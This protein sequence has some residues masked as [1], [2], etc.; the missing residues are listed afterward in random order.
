MTYVLIHLCPLSPDFDQ[1]RAF[2]ASK[3]EVRADRAEPN[4]HAHSDPT[5][6]CEEITGSL[7]HGDDS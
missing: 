5:L 4:I 2:S 6:G 1:I 3:M 7:N